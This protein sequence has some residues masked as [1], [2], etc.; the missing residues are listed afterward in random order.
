MFL[1]ACCLLTN[2]KRM[3]LYEGFQSHDVWFSTNLKKFPKIVHCQA[4]NNKGRPAFRNSPVLVDK[5]Q[6]SKTQIPKVGRGSVW[7]F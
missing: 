4:K 5:F 3:K 1:K 6:C 7:N 2:N